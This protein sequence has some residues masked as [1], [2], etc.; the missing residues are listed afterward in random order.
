M[1]VF[2][3]AT[4]VRESLPEALYSVIIARAKCIFLFLFLIFLMENSAMLKLQQCRFGKSRNFKQP[5]SSK[6]LEDLRQS[7]SNNIIELVVQI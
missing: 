6:Y 4:A 1:G 2:F 7:T 5:A 3:V